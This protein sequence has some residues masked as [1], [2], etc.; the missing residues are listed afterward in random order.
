M[1]TWIYSWIIY[2]FVFV[3][4][5]IAGTMDVK[6]R[7][8]LRLR[9]WKQFLGLRFD[10]GQPIEYWVH[11]AS[12]GELEYAVPILRELGARGKRALVT[13]YSISAKG[14]VEQ[15]RK[16]LPNVS[17]VVPL[18]H[19]GLG[20]MRE[21]VAL[22]KRQGVRYALLMKYELW[23]GLLWECNAQGVKILLVDALKPGWFHKRLLHKLDGILSGYS[24]EVSAIR[25][26]Y[27]RVVGDTRVERVLERVSQSKGVLD[28]VLSQDLRASLEERPVLV[29]GSM[30]PADDRI[31]LAAIRDFQRSG[32]QLNLIW[33]PHE[34]DSAACAKMTESLVGMG[35]EVRD[36]AQG[37]SLSGR[38]LAI[39]VMR[40]GVLA[41]LYGLGRCAYVGGGFGRGVH[42]VWEPALC[43][44]KVACGPGTSRSPESEELASV[45]VLTRI[46]DSDEL[47][48]WLAATMNK[49]TSGKGMASTPDEVSRLLQKH[50]GASGRIVQACEGM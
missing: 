33:V 44:A 39:T 22:V 6:V 26:P 32:G 36:I 14:P 43:G 45:G 38:P 31:M 1:K 47:G 12:H 11:V 35:F 50:V 40:K 20:L 8:T 29:C 30:W 7:E 41:E 19:D 9:S 42:S 27:V 5:R 48:A 37:G 10:A 21:F 2:P 15:L 16:A 3:L 49:T 13:Y 46:R 18:P 23:P 34:L 4:A 17:L 28:S 24:S 25:H